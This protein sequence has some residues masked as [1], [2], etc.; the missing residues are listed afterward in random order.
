MNNK[1]MEM[2]ASPV[3]PK[4][5]GLT[6]DEDALVSQ[7]LEIIGGIT[8]EAVHTL[9]EPEERDVWSV[10]E[11]DDSV[12]Y[13]DE[14][15]AQQ[16][17][18]ANT[19]CSFG[20]ELPVNSVTAD[21]NIQANGDEFKTGEEMQQHLVPTE[22]KEQRELRMPEPEAVVDQ[23]EATDQEVQSNQSPELSVNTCGGSLRQSA[24][25]QMQPELNTSAEKGK[26]TSHSCV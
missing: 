10:E 15:Q 3:P 25:M 13:S 6:V 22:D 9:E 1:A 7:V 11:G 20:E 2:Q 5:Q 23:S 4:T 18:R 24:D 26:K 8:L 21:E 17:V 12:F 19:A 14:D 16:D